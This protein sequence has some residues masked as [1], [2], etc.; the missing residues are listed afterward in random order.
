M[1]FRKFISSVVLLST[2][3]LANSSGALERDL[4]GGK[5]S[6]P[7]QMKFIYMNLIKAGGCQEHEKFENVSLFGQGCLE[8]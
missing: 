2:N 6:I 3:P 1:T 7:H 8:L 4:G 5:V